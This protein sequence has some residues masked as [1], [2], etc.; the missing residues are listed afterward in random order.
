MSDERQS[1]YVGVCIYC[2]STD[3]LTDEHAIPYALN[4]NRV[5]R[6]ASCTSCN[7][8]TTRF[9]RSILRKSML[10]VRTVLNMPTRRKRNRPDTLPLI[11]I[12]GDTRSEEL[13]P[14]S[15]AIPALVLPELGPPEV[16]PKMGHSMGLPAGSFKPKTHFIVERTANDHL[17]AILKKYSAD[18]VDVPWEINHDDFLR[19]IAKIAMCEAVSVYGF[20]SFESIY[21]KNAV[22]GKDRPAFWV[23]SDGMYDLHLQ[24]GF[25]DSS[26]VIAT[27]R[28]RGQ[29][30][31]WI[32][33]KLWNKS[34]TPEY[35]VV[36]GN[37][38]EITHAFSTL[39]G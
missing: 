29:Q 30:E 25:D 31:V 26:H 19:M 23:G 17:S 14:I 6:N 7:K 38:A 28:A 16:Y 11:F 24:G 39:T 2:S 33:V 36:S 5:L 27:L 37:C 34:I 35:V 32:K 3:D 10:A 21:I 4:G 1:T 8:V 20:A 12:R 22:L 13:V 15:D 18:S 9:E